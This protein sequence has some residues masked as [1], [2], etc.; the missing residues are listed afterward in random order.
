[1]KG[2]GIPPR[3]NLNEHGQTGGNGEDKEKNATGLERPKGMVTRGNRGKVE[4]PLLGYAS[5]TNASCQLCDCRRCIKE[6][7]TKGRGRGKKSI[8]G[9][10]SSRTLPSLS[11]FGLTTNNP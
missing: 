7:R 4:K 11:Q 10:V 1:L 9:E 2:S 5:R 6:I 8:A 3:S